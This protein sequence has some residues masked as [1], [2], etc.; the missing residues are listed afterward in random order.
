MVPL[1]GFP[2]NNYSAST[3]VAFTFHT[4]KPQASVRAIVP[5]SPLGLDNVGATIGMVAAHNSGVRRKDR[6]LRAWDILRAWVR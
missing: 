4:T 1:V 5:F 3:T 6:Q 2:L